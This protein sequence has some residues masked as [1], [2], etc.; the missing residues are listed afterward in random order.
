[1]VVPSDL[2]LRKGHFFHLFYRVLHMRELISHDKPL[3]I[4]Y[5]FLSSSNSLD[6]VKSNL[7][8]WTKR[9]G[10]LPQSSQQQ[11]ETLSA[12]FKTGAVPEGMVNVALGSLDQSGP[13][14]M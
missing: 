8:T 11:V 3:H 14:M 2:A 6:P 12:S 5:F 1:M 9:F 13:G 7:K 10:T 4:T